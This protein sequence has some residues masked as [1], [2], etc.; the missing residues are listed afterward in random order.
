MTEVDPEL[1]RN[2][3]P[4][5]P[6]K[7]GNCGVQC[8]L[9]SQMLELDSRKEIAALFGQYALTEDFVRDVEER[10][11]PEEVENFAAFTRNVVGNSMEEIDEQIEAIQREIDNNAQ[12]CDGTFKMRAT[13]NGVTYTASVCTSSRVYASSEDNKAHIATHVQ[14][15]PEQK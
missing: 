9:A 8:D 2:E 13:K 1:L 15:K 7:C 11:S 12:V 10:I 14:A 4:L 5:V 6:S 3:V